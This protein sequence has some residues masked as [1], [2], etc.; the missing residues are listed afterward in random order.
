MSSFASCNPTET[1]N[2]ANSEVCQESEYRS[3]QVIAVGKAINLLQGGSG[4]HSD[5]YSGYYWN[6]E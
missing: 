2:S 6:N 5:S 4:K 1:V 3:P